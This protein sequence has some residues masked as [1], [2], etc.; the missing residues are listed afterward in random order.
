[1]KLF[2]DRIKTDVPHLAIEIEHGPEGVLSIYIRISASKVFET[3]E[4]D[5]ADVFC[6][7][8][9]EGNLVGIEMINP[10]SVHFRKVLRKIASKFN[11]TPLEN[12][13]SEAK[14]YEQVIHA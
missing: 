13:L 12:F 8:D 11:V 1:M 4:M 6:D 3:M 14:K 9:R 2:R 7:L 5:E 10:G